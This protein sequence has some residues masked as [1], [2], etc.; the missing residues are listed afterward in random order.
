MA[1]RFV[2]EYTSSLAVTPASPSQSP[3]REKENQTP[4]TFGRILKESSRQ[5]NLFGASLRTSQDILQS[6]SPQFIEA[7]DLWVMML[8]QDYLV[9]MSALPL[10][11]DNAFSSWPTIAVSDGHFS[12]CDP[13]V[14]IDGVKNGN[15]ATSQLCA[16]VA[17]EQ[18]GLL[19]P[20]SPSTHGKSQELWS[21]PRAANIEESIET[22]MDRRRRTGQGYSNVSAEVNQY[23]K[24]KL[25]P[26]WVEQLMGLTV[27]W[28]DLDSWETE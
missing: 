26:D 1:D 21:T 3:A 19:A 8:R 16:I 7:Y 24:G 20:D 13:K 15:R 27:G 28:T 12:K 11:K 18:G 9:R 23:Q 25:N 2:A 22:I 4:D 17:A 6:D 14:L 10:T 5:L